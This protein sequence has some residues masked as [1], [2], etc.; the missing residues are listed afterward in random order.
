MQKTFQKAH[1]DL[2]GAGLVELGV[3][4]EAYLV[5]GG[6]ALLVISVHQFNDLQ[7]PR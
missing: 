5:A 7:F 2:S 1:H 3:L 4:N 6:N